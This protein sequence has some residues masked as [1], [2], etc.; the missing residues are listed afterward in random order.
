[1]V[2]LTGITNAKLQFDLGMAHIAFECTPAYPVGN[3][4]LDTECS[5]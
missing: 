2:E 4:S 5:K 3:Q 1:M